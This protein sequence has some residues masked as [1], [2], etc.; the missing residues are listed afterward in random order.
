MSRGTA[1][2]AIARRDAASS[3]PPRPRRPRRTSK[4]GPAHFLMPPGGGLGLPG[5]VG[6]PLGFSIV[7]EVTRL[8]TLVEHLVRANLACA[9]D[10]LDS[11]RQIV[12]FVQLTL[13]RLSRQWLSETTAQEFPLIL[14]LTDSPE[15]IEGTPDQDGYFYLILDP[16]YCGYCV[17]GP[18][19]ERMAEIHPRLPI[20][21]F[22]LFHRPLWRLFRVYNYDDA[23]QRVEYLCECGYDEEG[24][25]EFI[26]NVKAAIPASLELQELSRRSWRR[27]VADCGCPI[28][29]KLFAAADRV[30]EAAVPLKIPQLTRNQE[31]QLGDTNSP[32]PVLLTVFQR[33]DP[34]EGIFDEEMQYANELP[35]APNVIVPFRP[36][37]RREAIDAFRTI[38]RV[39]IVI[40]AAARVLTMIPGNDHK[41]EEKERL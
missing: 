16:D 19:L 34:I 33:G 11:K 12:S 18:M 37:N 23:K 30:R 2:R 41:Y 40:E 1:S 26:R 20:T 3:F 28:V 36:E 31:E 22:N 39:C 24:E 17:I 21:F 5:L 14:S 4:L 29:Q 10:W 38:E 32:L 25:A 9:S 15:Q 7:E 27:L 6:V 13:E 8:T 35:P